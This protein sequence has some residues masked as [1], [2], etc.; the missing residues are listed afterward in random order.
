MLEDVKYLMA[1]MQDDVIPLIKHLKE[2]LMPSHTPAK[3]KKAKKKGKK[4]VKK[5]LG[6]KKKKKGKK[7][8]K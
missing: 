4:A 7:K 3:R 5:A 2:A 1:V 6:S 8:R